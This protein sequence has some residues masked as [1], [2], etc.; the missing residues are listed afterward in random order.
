MSNPTRALDR[1]DERIHRGDSSAGLRGLPSTVLRAVRDGDVGAL[2]V[3][4]GLLVIGIIFS[5]LNPFFL[6]SAN[7]V[8]L[9]LQSAA[10]GTIALGVVFILLG[11]QIDLSVGSVSGLSASMLAVMF[12][13]WEWPMWATIALALAIGPVFGAIY[14]L[15]FVRF[16]V[17][18]FVITLAGLLAILG[19]Q[20]HTLGGN[21]SI[22]IPFDSWLVHFAQQSFLAPWES[23]VLV[24]ATVAAFVVSRLRR[25]Q[26]RRAANLSVGPVWHVGLIAAVLLVGL[27]SAVW[28][29]NQSRGVSIMFLFFVVLVCLSQ[30]ALTRTSWGR[31]VYAV[32]GNV[33]A[34]R[35]SGIRV[36]RVYVSL[37]MICSTLAATGGLM[38]AG[39]L[40]SANPSS[41]GGDVNL[42]AIAAAVIGGTS[43]FGGRGNAYSALL[44]VLVIGA[45]ANGLTL[46][47]LSSDIQF[48]ITGCVL[49]A[50]VILDS[51]SRQSR[52]AHGRA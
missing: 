1:Q 32:G 40:A 16:G 8:N 2:P 45:I 3:V 47:N 31:S 17:P 23:Y 11:G 10:L 5:S 41:G 34:A 36:T 44:G 39:R 27:G 48:M 29:I 42:N 52:M 33:E 37:F 21:G 28:Y 49:L 19:L 24:V 15:L 51:V 14:G 20:L 50:A 26:R 43:L 30:Y 38:A 46:L 6:S 13:H 18:S 9:M 25:A 7:L 35:R 22:N 4:L 12:V